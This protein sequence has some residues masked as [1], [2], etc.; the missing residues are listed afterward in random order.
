M[1]V[2]L[3]EEEVKKAV[4]LYLQSDRVVKIDTRKSLPSSIKIRRKSTRSEDVGSVAVEY[5]EI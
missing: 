5:K 3:T 1:K 2:V 4:A